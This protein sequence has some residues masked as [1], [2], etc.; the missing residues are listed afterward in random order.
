MARLY[1][2]IEKLNEIKDEL[3]E[4]FPGRLTET[5]KIE[6]LKLQLEADRI[7]RLIDTEAGKID[8]IIREVQNKLL[9][10]LYFKDCPSMNKLQNDLRELSLLLC[11]DLRTAKDYNQLCMIK[12]NEEVDPLATANQL[13]EAVDKLIN[14]KIEYDK[15]IT[16]IK[17]F[18]NTARN[19]PY[20]TATQ[21][22]INGIS[23]ALFGIAVF[24]AVIGVTVAMVATSGGFSLAMV[25]AFSFAAGLTLGLGGGSLVGIMTASMDE[26]PN[27][28]GKAVSQGLRSLIQY[29]KELARPKASV[30]SNDKP[31]F[32]F[33]SG[34]TGL[35]MGGP[36]S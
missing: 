19:S 29:R 3:Q 26:T 23:G 34:S 33:L 15:Q 20:S 22:L 36:S 32:E 6:K 30:D 5:E 17:K 35:G 28:H 8:L 16:A 7:Q 21:I 1:A 9:G 4:F 11:K 27:D 18:R 13:K 14:P 10:S 25:P 24:A 12:L 2:E 31:E